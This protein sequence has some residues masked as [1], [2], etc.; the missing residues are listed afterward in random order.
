MSV[1]V[2]KTREDIKNI[3]VSAAKAA[4]KKGALPKAELTDFIVEKPADSTHGDFAVNAAMT[5]ARVFKK[6]PAMIASAILENADFEG[7]YIEKAEMAGPGFINF[8]LGDKYY[9]DVVYEIESKKEAYGNSDIGKGKRIVVEFVSANPTGPMHIGNARGG[10]LGDCLAAVFEKAGYE[11]VREFYIN[12]AGNQIEKFA[13][14]LEARYLQIYKPETEFPEDGYHGADIIDRA[15]E[16]AKINGDKYLDTDSAVRRKALVE[17]A[18]PI[19]IEGLKTDLESYRINYDVWFKESVLHSDGELWGTIEEMKQ[20]GLTY[21]KDGALWYKAT[22]HG[23]EKDEVLVRANGIPTYFAA[24][25]AY[26]VNKFKIRG[27][28][29]AVNVWG[30]DHHGHVARMKGALDALGLNGDDLHI[31]L[32]Q[33]V[34]LVRDGEVVRVSKRTGKSITLKTLLDEVPLDA[35]R[36]IFNSKEPN[37]HL[38]FDLDLAVEQSSQ[39]PVYYVQYA[40]ARICSIMRTAKEQGRE[41]ASCTADDLCRL[42][43]PEERELIS[44]LAALTTE[45]ENCAAYYDSA[46]LTRY[47]YDLATLFHKFY[48]AC[49]CMCDD[50]SLT[51]ARLTLCD[52]TATVIKIVLAMLKIDAPER[53]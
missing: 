49:R 39:N 28:D 50:E 38:E 46:K 5:W 27:F 32:M 1:L 51:K 33:L 24:D 42:T 25:I 6:A 41:F 45:I 26:H 2:K 17:F 34:R 3:V 29:K 8:Y 36:F 48:N 15:N 7:T 9:A 43:A 18:L 21:E 13:G 16:F 10:A 19:N 44:H 22:E 4:I 37:T 23:G 31:V 12:D 20:R 14:S 53:M 47:V 11:T 52:A 35:A 40:Y 30:A